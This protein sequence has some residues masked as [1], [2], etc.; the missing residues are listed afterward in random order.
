MKLPTKGL[1]EYYMDAKLAGGHWQCD[2]GDGTCA[3]MDDE[4]DFAEK[5][6]T[7]RSNE[8][9]YVF[10]VSCS[11]GAVRRLAGRFVLMPD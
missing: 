6:N 7:E 8:F 3:E 1:G 10:D 2:A 11:L 4:I 5:D 9:K